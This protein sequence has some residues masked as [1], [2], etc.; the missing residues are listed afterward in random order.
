MV[1]SRE[2]TNIGVPAAQM[3][4]EPILHSFRL[5]VNGPAPFRSFPLKSGEASPA[6]V[7]APRKTEPSDAALSMNSGSSLSPG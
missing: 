1:C 2:R 4:Q 7:E 5:T 6:K 3:Q